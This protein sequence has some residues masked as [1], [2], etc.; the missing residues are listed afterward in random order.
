MEKLPEK[1]RRYG[2][3][4]R[5]IKRNKLV[6]MY[7]MVWVNEETGTERVHCYEVFKIRIQKA[8]TREI[9]GHGTVEYHAKEKLPAN[10]EF[11][12]RAWA[13]GTVEMAE[14]IFERLTQEAHQEQGV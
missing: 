4:Y 13:P 1:F 7:A 10:E 3:E 9:P 2:Y 5:L 8:R 12:Y 11:G 6:A 14:E